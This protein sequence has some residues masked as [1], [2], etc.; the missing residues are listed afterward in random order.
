MSLLTARPVLDDRDPDQ[1]VRNF[2]NNWR[3]IRDVK[4][5]TTSNFFTRTGRIRTEGLA[6]IEMETSGFSMEIA[7]SR[8]VMLS[9]PNGNAL[10]ELTFAIWKCGATPCVVSLLVTSLDCST[11][12][13]RWHSTR[14]CR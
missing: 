11:G 6:I 9:L 4:P 2:R 14:A 5:R 12:R 8:F 7:D 13:Q 10:Y 3:E 1:L